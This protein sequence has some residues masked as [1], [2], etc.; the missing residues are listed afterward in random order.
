MADHRGIRR[1]FAI[2]MP[3]LTSLIDQ[4]SQSCDVLSIVSSFQSLDIAIA[5]AATVIHP[6]R[7]AGLGKLIGCNDAG[8]W[9]VG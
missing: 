4:A 8:N 1:V 5:R 3:G 2:P 9:H 7:A 6:S